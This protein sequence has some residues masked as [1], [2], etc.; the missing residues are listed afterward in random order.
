[1]GCSHWNSGKK[2]FVLRKLESWGY[3][4][5]KT[6]W[7]QVEPFRHNTSVWW[8][9]GQTD[10]QPISI[11][12]AVW[13]MHVKNATYKCS[14]LTPLVGH[15]ERPLAC[16]KS[17]FNNLQRSLGKLW[18]PSLTCA[19]Y[20]K[21]RILTS[22]RR[23]GT[24]KY[25]KFDSNRNSLRIRIGRFRFDSKVTGWFEIFES[26]APAVIPQTILTV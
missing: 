25:S 15:Q 8:T 12:C 13:L 26:A 18:A 14:A 21:P 17:C 20:T 22:H 10:V 6:V 4:G 23:L 7:R 19:S 11:T 24:C 2:L 16:N 3:K 1:M 5:V 9:D